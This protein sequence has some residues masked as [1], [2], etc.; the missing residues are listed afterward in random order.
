MILMREINK[1]FIYNVLYQIFIYIIPLLTVP[2][3]SRILGANNIGVYSY[4]YSI[5]YYFMLVGMLGINNY[6]SRK[7]ARF[8]HD[9]KEMSKEFI[10]IYLLQLFLSLLMIICYL[11][12]IM[13][14]F[15]NYKMIFGIQVIYLIS[16][17]F[18]INWFYFGI[19]K[20]KITISR[21][22]IIKV[23]SL[24]LIFTLVKTENDLWIYTLI[25]SGS[26]LISQLYLWLFIHKYIMPV[27]VSFKDVFS[28]FKKCVILFIP[29]IA[30]SIY[31]VMDKTMLG[32][33]SGT[34]ELGY[35]ENA[36]KI[37]NIPIS[38]ITAL[39][40]VMLPHMSKLKSDEIKLAIES[41]FELCFCFV[42]PM[43]F[44][45]F[46]ISS[47]FSIMFFGNEF[48]KTGTIIKLLIPTILFSAITNVIRTN[49]LIPQEKDSIYV[50]STIYGAITNL[51]FNSIFI[52]KYGAYGACIGTLIAEFSVMIYQIINVKKEIDFKKVFKIM[53]VYIIKSL[54]MSIFMIIVGLSFKNQ[55][56]RLILQFIMAPI[57]YIIS[58]HKYIIYDFLGKKVTK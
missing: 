22:I 21:N 8:S 52:P 14:F 54:V 47:D 40:T 13:L 31:R 48:Y 20:F 16:V 57:I 5:V 41:S 12:I 25:V 11:I 42:M 19:E 53:F 38:F 1:N 35:Y 32:L 51:I 2:Y 7:I 24:I 37:I 3:I 39:G 23:L 56:I 50:K 17:V 45:L 6:G 49:Y 34:L 29:V 10:S 9:K 15:K 46:I 43:I 30:Y 33:I 28:H 58:I 55:Y 18:D 27:K 26:T 44:G 4:T 36:E